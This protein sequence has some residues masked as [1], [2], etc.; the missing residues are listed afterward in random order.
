[1]TWNFQVGDK[2]LYIDAFGK[3][4][5]GKITG[6][7]ESCGDLSMIVENEE[8]LCRRFM[9]DGRKTRHDLEPSVLPT[10]TK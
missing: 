8:G 10:E 6:F 7:D 3:H 5:E 9:P 4:K 2:V 1:M